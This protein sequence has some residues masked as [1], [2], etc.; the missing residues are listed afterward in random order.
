[1]E[2]QQY[3]DILLEPQ[4][5]VCARDTH[6]HFDHRGNVILRNLVEKYILP[7]GRAA[8]DDEKNKVF[9]QVEAEARAAKGS[10]GRTPRFL[11]PEP[12]DDEGHV[13]SY[14]EATPEEVNIEILGVIRLHFNSTP[15]EGDVVVRGGSTFECHFGNLRLRYFV[16][17]LH[18]M[19][20]VSEHR[21]GMALAVRDIVTLRG[22]HFLLPFN[23]NCPFHCCIE[24]DDESIKE[25][26]ADLL[27]SEKGNE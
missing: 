13:I 9:A 22:S 3:D 6:L 25:W 2:E 26:I 21:R 19:Y 15:D 17:S 24:A 27:L 1:M 8:T 5:Y 16:K 10:D 11:V 14:R 23:E 7:F 12:H 4:D 18:R 20:P